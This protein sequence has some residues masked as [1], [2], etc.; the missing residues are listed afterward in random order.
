[1]LAAD[2]GHQ[3][4]ADANAEERPAV[5]QHALFERL[6]HA[7]NGVEAAPAI[8]EGADAGQHDAG[9]SG[10]I[11]RLAG[12]Q[13][14]LVVAAV[15]RGAL[16]SFRRCVKIARA[17]IDDGDAH[18]GAPGSGNRPITSEAFGAPRRTGVA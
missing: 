7:G 18:R 3:L 14:R 10:D 5:F 2:I 16:K 4:H 15:A 11:I 8:G 13:D 9:G 1:M 6:D 17:V 12:D